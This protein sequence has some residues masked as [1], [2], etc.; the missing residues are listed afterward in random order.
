MKHNIKYIIENM[1]Y[2]YVLGY[3]AIESVYYF[4]DIIEDAYFFYEEDDA[5]LFLKNIDKYDVI[6]RIDDIQELDVVE[7]EL[8]VKPL[9]KLDLKLEY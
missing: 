7:V 2:N 8:K 1:Y 4:T 5:K 9:Y 6:D 3:D